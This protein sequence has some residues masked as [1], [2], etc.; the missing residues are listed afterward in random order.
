[1]KP[2]VLID[3]AFRKRDL[4]FSAADWARVNAVC[5]V[6]WGLDAE[7]PAAR[8]EEFRDVQV[9]VSG[10][11]RHGKLSDWPNLR[12]FMEVGGGLPSPDHLDYQTAFERQIRI[13]S[14]SPAFGPIVAE[15]G[16]G[17]ALAA[18]RQIARTDREF[19]VGEEGWSHEQFRGEFSLYGKTVGFIGYGALG[20]CLRHL[21][22]PWGV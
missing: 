6:A 20:R 3:T 19:R 11:W 9:I 8:Y 14:C 17:L 5:E 18:A 22:E 1:M 21:L 16:L 10:W 2:R 13:L 4:I 7:L 15:M 12:A